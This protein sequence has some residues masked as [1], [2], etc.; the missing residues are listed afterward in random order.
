MPA[1]STFTGLPSPQPFVL[2]ISG[3]SG[4]GKTVICNHLIRDD[5]L[6][7]RSVSATTRP[8]RP[9][10][11]D[12]VAYHFWSEDRFRR[13][14]E[15]DLFLEWAE[16]HGHHYG[17]PRAPVEEHLAA[18]RYPVLNVDVQGGH[19]VKG[20]LGHD[21]VLILVAPPAMDALEKRLRGRGSDPEEEIRTRLVNAAGELAEWRRYDYAV[22]NDVLEDAVARVRAVITA[23]RSRVDR[24]ARGPRRG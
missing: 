9:D 19:S 3:P 21:A 8:R 11:T 13:E 18:G 17:T 14:A 24:L 6:L 23:E 16:V 7:V 10:E 2:V 5:S 1:D 12:G 15:R 4:V 20:L 22:V